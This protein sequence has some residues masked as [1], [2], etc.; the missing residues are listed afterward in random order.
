MSEQRTK[1][2]VVEQRK[3][4]WRRER[5]RQAV[6]GFQLYVSTYSDQP[7][8]QDYY[9]ETFINDMLYGI[10]LAMQTGTPT[11]YSGPGGF[12]RFKQRLREH[13]K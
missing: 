10:G 3:L 8:Y 2:P 13:L 4:E 6:A 5:M 12:E 1:D 11:D 9:D 7:G